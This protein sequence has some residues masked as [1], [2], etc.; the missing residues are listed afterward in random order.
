MIRGREPGARE[1]SSSEPDRDEP[2]WQDEYAL[3]AVLRRRASWEDRRPTG[4][5]PVLKTTFETVS[6]GHIPAERAPVLSIAPGAPVS[7]QTLSHQGIVNDA[8]PIAFLGSLGIRPEDILPEVTEV[9]ARTSRPEGASSHLLT[10]PIE[11]VGAEPGDSVEIHI[12]EAELRVDYGINISGPGRGLLPDLL[13]ATHVR[14]LRRDP[15]GD[16]LAFTDAITIPIDPF[17]GFVGLAPDPTDGPVGAR[18]PGRWGGNL[19]LRLLTAGSS[20]ILPVSRSGGHLY[21]G[22]P[23]SAQGHGE[24][25]GTAVEHSAT[26]MITTTLHK[27]RTVSSALVV[28]PSHI[29]LTGIAPECEVALQSALRSAIDLICGWTD[30][31][32]DR[33]DA[34][35]LC[36]IAA[37]VGLAEVV[38]G[39]AV[40]YVAVPRAVLPTH[41]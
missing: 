22:D 36:S 4:A 35:A 23:H 11:I 34:Y 5:V 26:F 13:D 1:V 16:G 2:D 24:V 37:D 31:A 20:I 10:G 40:A 3:A 18:T 41:R 7:V 25:N 21:I 28:T 14:L 27:A 15:T 38:N 33:A 32:L 39:A 29:I 30:S 8:D 19:D 12:L 17:P 9:V 6:W